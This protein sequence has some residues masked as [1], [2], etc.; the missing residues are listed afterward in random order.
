M[1]FGYADG[2]LCSSAVDGL[3]RAAE[4]AEAGAAT[5]VVLG[6]IATATDIID[7]A[8]A[9]SWLLDRAAARMGWLPDELNV[10]LALVAEA[11]AAVYGDARI[12]GKR[13]YPIDGG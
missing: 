11:A 9:S 12:E 2:L 3:S 10:A 13:R 7:A 6:E 8:T 4:A 1:V 5:E